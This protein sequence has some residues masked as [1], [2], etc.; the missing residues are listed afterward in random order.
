MVILN[1][2]LS[3]HVFVCNV[4]YTKEYSQMELQNTRKQLKKRCQM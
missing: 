3:V 2:L 1:V 4:S